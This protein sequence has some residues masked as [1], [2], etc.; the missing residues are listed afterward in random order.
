[1]RL[2]RSLFSSP[3]KLEPPGGIEKVRYLALTGRASLAD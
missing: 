1:M 2:S 3:V